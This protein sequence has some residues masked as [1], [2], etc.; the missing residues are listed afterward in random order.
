M[1]IQFRTIFKSSIAGNLCL[2][3][4]VGKCNCNACIN[5]WSCKDDAACG[6]L[7]GACD[8][9]SNTC[10][11]WEVRWDWVGVWYLGYLGLDI[12]RYTCR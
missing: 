9:K 6:G 5:F 7:K 2:G 12:K 8:M 4:F 1:F 11:C 3:T 10:R